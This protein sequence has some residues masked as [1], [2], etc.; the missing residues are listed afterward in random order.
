MDDN[1]FLFEIAELFS[2]L[3]ACLDNCDP[4]VSFSS[5]QQKDVSKMSI[6]YLILEKLCIKSTIPLV[7]RRMH[8][9]F[10]LN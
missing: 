8:L 4:N 9:V 3:R 6:F 10:K 5:G 7:A 2:N 1:F